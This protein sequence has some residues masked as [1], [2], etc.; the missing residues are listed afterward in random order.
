MGAA[1]R[2]R[3]AASILPSINHSAETLG[4]SDCNLVD[5]AGYLENFKKL[6]VFYEAGIFFELPSV[7]KCYASRR[8]TFPHISKK[9]QHSSF[10][11][12]FSD[13]V[14][15]AQSASGQDQGEADQRD[16]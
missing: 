2:I 12:D 6:V 9:T 4:V 1:P 10:V 3:R 8:D 13:L 11:I 5:R 7:G 14:V 16:R 15:S